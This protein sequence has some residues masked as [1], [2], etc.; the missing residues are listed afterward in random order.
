MEKNLIKIARA[1]PPNERVP[2]AFEKRIMAH[3]AFG[4]PDLW[5][6][7]GFSLWKAAAPCVAIMLL[8][9]AYH[10]FTPAPE[11][12]GLDLETA[13]LAPLHNDVSW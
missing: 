3:L 11:T 6:E 5:I 1:L 10:S 7:W 13:L 2:M 4:P 8:A 12:N 9:T